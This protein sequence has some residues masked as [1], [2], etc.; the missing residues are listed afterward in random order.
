LPIYQQ[1]TQLDDS[2]LI[3]E[4]PEAL[5]DLS[6]KLAALLEVGKREHVPIHVLH[7]SHWWHRTAGRLQTALIEHAHR[8]G[9]PIWG[10]GQWLRFTQARRATVLRSQG[11]S[12]E[13]I[14]AADEVTLWVEGAA[15]V[16]VDG[17]RRSLSRVEDPAGS[18]GLLQLTPG[19]H[20]VE[21]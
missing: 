9:L 20:R 10:E 8:L 17:Q 15:S 4:R 7:H 1:A 13:V 6:V 11:Q 2:A 18:Y 12:F 5:Q 19:A 16:R 21:P 3:D 14:V